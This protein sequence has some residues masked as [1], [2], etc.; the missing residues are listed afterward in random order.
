MSRSGWAAICWATWWRA[1]CEGV[2]VIEQR[3]VLASGELQ[4]GVGG[5]G[6]AACLFAAREVDAGV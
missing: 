3:D 1:S 5:G 6:D 4:D 2:V